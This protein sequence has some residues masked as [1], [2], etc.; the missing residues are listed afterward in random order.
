MNLLRK[1]IKLVDPLSEWTGRICSWIIVPIVLLVVMEVV[2]RRFLGRPTIW[3]FETTTQMY[4]FH[5]MILAAF[6]LLYNAHVSVD[7]LTMYLSAKNRAL[8]EI[9]TYVLFFFPFCIIC[10]YQGISFA[11][12]SWAM[13]ETTWSVFAPPVYPLKTIIPVTFFL[14]LLQGLSNFFKNILILKGESK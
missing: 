13:K 2:L 9:I 1:Y 8:V 14:L 11:Q 10:M 3:S 7:I 4:A 6:G 5:F 12:T